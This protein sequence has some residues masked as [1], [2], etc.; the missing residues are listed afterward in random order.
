MGQFQL[1]LQ[2]RMKMFLDKRLFTCSEC[3]VWKPGWSHG[4]GACKRDK[5]ADNQKPDSKRMIDHVDNLYNKSL[6]RLNNKA[7][8]N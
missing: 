5:N 1:R 8:I 7:R 4:S 2:L 3:R 6:R